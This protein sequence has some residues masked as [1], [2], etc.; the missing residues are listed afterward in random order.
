LEVPLKKTQPTPIPGALPPSD[1]PQFSVEGLRP[2]T[3]VLPKTSE[4]VGEILKLANSQHWGVIPFG[5]GTKQGVGA[6][7][8][9]YDVAISLQN[10]NQIP[11]YEPQDLVVRV[12]SGCRLT[13]LQERLAHD[14]L[15]L[16]VD[17]PYYGESTLGGIVACN[18]SGPSR[19]A[20]GT[21]RDYLLG[22][23][24]IQP[25]GARTKFGARVVKNVTGYDMCKLYTG[26]FGT[27]G[28]LIDFY[29]KLKP[30]PPSEKSVLVVLSSL[31]A[32]G[33]ALEKLFNSCLAPAAME[34]L[35]PEA[36]RILE[37]CISLTGN[38]AGYAFAVRFE[39]VENAVKWQV[40]QLEKLWE[41][42]GVKGVILSD[43]AE[44]KLFWEVLREDRP[45]LENSQGPGVK[46]KV[47][48][49]PSQLVDLTQR[50]ESSE[51]RLEGKVSI[52]SHT[53][54]GVVRAYF[55]PSGSFRPQ[56]MADF[57]RELRA[58]LKPARGS[59]IVESAPLALKKT[60]DVWGYDYK[61]RVLMQQIKQKYDPGGVL[62][63]G[64]FV[65]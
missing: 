35:N 27:L 60:V 7:P 54:S 26:S 49:L 24:V 61:E 28:I 31:P 39:D 16:P 64:R 45:Y 44:Q 18:A 4:E 58:F 51:A 48:S 52:K 53:G 12:E 23:S 13:H 63:P 20:H 41:S 33:E 2:Q 38:K 3:A 40:G 29:F 59:V 30:L 5:A 21:I 6:P 1:L 55:H 17:P 37:E 11:E 42:Y 34:F 56:A 65:V 43:R 10:F 25:D 62:N 46:L 8:Q 32:A 14:N 47:N 19:F 15:Y 22:V 57:I 50:L 9:R 36:L